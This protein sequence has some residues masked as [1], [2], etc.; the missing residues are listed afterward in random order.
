MTPQGID[1]RI[2]DGEIRGLED[3]M[4]IDY[5]MDSRKGQIGEI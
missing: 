5:S 1:D 4:V 2:G 3:G